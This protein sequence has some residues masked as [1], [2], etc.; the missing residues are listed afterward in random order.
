MSVEIME[1]VARKTRFVAGLSR[2]GG[3][4]GGD[5]SPKTSF[6]IFKGIEA[7]VQFKLGKASVDGLTVAV[8]GVGNV[9]YH[10]CKFLHEAGAKLIVA[11]IDESRVRRIADEFGGRGVTLENILSQKVDVVSPCALGAI[12]NERSISKLQT[13]I[14]AGGANNQLETQED[15]QRLHD[16]GILYAPDYVI[17]GGGIINVAC[18]YYGDAS[19]E[20]VWD[21]VAAIGPRLT[22]IF[23]QS[24]SSG[25]PTNVVANEQAKKIIAGAS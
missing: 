1:K 12:I 5:P 9:G 2:K 16:A 6:G 10:L 4:A 19:D 20:E 7:A 11:D 22:G 15:G 25:K 17:N 18:E 13:T 14:I 3:L 24:A 23:E 8:Q 21:R